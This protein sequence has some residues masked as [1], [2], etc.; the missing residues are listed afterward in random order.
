MNT[1]IFDVGMYF[2]RALLANCCLKIYSSISYQGE[3]KQEHTTVK[4]NCKLYFI[5]S[6]SLLKGRYIYKK[7]LFLWYKRCF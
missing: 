2:A 5:I 7:I 3:T 1:S 4:V 6:Y